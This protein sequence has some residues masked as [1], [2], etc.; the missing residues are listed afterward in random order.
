M[1]KNWNEVLSEMQRIVAESA[2]NFAP[3]TIQNVKDLIAFASDHC[4]VSDEITQGYWPTICLGWST[5]APAPIEIEVHK[6]R[7]EFYRFFDG[8]TDIEDF[9]HKPGEPIPDGLIVHLS[10]VRLNP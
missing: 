3:E 4:I 2:D 5:T 9:N 7:Y 8:R 10:Q 6:E 1:Y